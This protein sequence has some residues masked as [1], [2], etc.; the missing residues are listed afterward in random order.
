MATETAKAKGN[1]K[2]RLIDEIDLDQKRTLVFKLAR[3]VPPRGRSDKGD[4]DQPYQPIYQVKNPCLVYDEAT[5]RER[6]LRLLKGHS[7][8]WRDEQEQDKTLTQ[9]EISALIV[10]PTFY[11]GVLQAKLPVDK[12]LVRFLMNHDD[13]SEKENRIGN[14]PAVFTLLNKEKEGKT[15]I[16]FL[17]KRKEATD[18]ALMAPKDDMLAHCAYLNIA[19]V[20]EFGQDYSEDYIRTQYVA[21]SEAKPI[22]FLNTFKSAT[23]KTFQAVRAAINSG[24]I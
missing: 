21:A 17:R 11:S 19:T 2:K 6:W 1:E 22:D 20:D 24:I 3:T 8:I 18:A 12:A 9:R 16:D 23:L 7:S 10:K 5:G 15:N 4:W 14:R 13:F